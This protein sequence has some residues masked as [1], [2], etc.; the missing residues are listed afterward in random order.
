MISQNN[1]KTIKADYRHLHKIIGLILIL[2]LLGWTLTGIIFLTKPGYQDAYE[3]LTI[4]KYPLHETLDSSLARGWEEAKY[5]RTKLGYH[6]IL[7]R[8]GISHHVDPITLHAKE[9]P[10]AQDIEQLVADAIAFNPSRY[11]EILKVSGNE[12]VTSTNVHITLS[13]TTMSLLQSGQDTRLIDKL[14]KL[15]YLQWSGLALPDKVIGISALVLLLLLTLLGL[16]QTISKQ[17]Q[18][19]D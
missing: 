10:S 2:P 1:I 11:G 7:T 13:W 17:S 15:H 19:P 9:S 16:Y 12:V 4:K 18:N 8:N 14:Y 5:F 3:Q 6:L